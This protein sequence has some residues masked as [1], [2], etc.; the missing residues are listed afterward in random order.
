MNYKKS[1]EKAIDHLI[2]EEGCP[3]CGP[4][5]TEQDKICMRC[6]KSNSDTTERKRSCWH[7][8]FGTE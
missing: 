6:L 4:E 2:S 8:L 7:R 3:N 5:D 1:Y